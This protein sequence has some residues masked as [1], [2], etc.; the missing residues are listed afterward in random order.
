M[1]HLLFAIVALALLLPQVAAGQ[2]APTERPGVFTITSAPPEADLKPFLRVLPDPSG[3]YA[4]QDPAFLFELGRREA[5]PVEDPVLDERS[6]VFLTVRNATD[7][8]ADWVTSFHLP[9]IDT[10]AFFVFDDDGHLLSRRV[11]GRAHH[12]LDREFPVVGHHSSFLFRPHQTYHLAILFESASPPPPHLSEL[13]FQPRADFLKTAYRLNIALYIALGIL[14][15]LTIYIFFLWIRLRD[16]SHLW[17][18]AFCLFSLLMWSTHYELFRFLFFPSISSVLANYLAT[19]A[20]VLSIL[21][22]TRAFLQLPRIA[23]R[24]ARLF[25]LKAA[26]MVLILGTLPFLGHTTAPYILNASAAG[27]TLILVAVAT[28][29][30][31]MKK[32][33]AAPIFFIGF[34]IFFF[35]STLTVFDALFFDLPTATIRLLTLI[36]TA[37]GVLTMALSVA[38]QIQYLQT[39]IVRARHQ[40]RTDA[41]TGLRNRAALD[42]DLQV[43]VADVQR[44]T[45]ADLVFLFCDLDGLK[46]LNDSEGHARGDELIEAFAG[47]L[48]RHFRDQDRYYRVG[49]D[50]FLVLL[51]LRDPDEPLTWLEDR[52]TSLSNSLQERGFSRFGVSYGAA[53]LSEVDG[54][55]DAA[56]ELADSR[57]Y[58]MKAEHRAQASR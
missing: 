40:A 1:K 49:G 27:L 25:E 5:R 21:L 51:P 10:V 4:I 35:S 31:L 12:A 39:G 46:A 20:M 2:S 11:S 52:M 23:P 22:F 47:E 19:G 37:L 41:L 55:L 58:A 13:Q 7:E 48:R 44:G 54:D 36:T 38:N 53:R 50:E 57:M 17:F 33:E 16:E 26:V 24:L 3:A 9:A 14:L 29:V 30:S 45:L 32:V 56:H 34:C 8:P 18:S 42:D 15:A 6:W 28:A 43:R